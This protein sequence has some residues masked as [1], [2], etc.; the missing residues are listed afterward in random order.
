MQE[1]LIKISFKFIFRSNPPEVFLAKGVLKIWSK[2]KG[3]YPCRN[4]IS[5]KLLCSFTEIAL[6]RGCSPVNLFHIFITP[7]YKNTS[8]GLPLHIVSLIISGKSYT[9]HSWSNP[10]NFLMPSGN[11]K[12]THTS[13]NLHLKAFWST[14]RQNGLTHFSHW[15]VRD[16]GIVKFC[17]QWGKN[18]ITSF[19]HQ[20]HHLSFK[21][22]VSQKEKFYPQFF[23][24]RVLF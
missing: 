6:R 1:S 2:V 24:K 14:H 19:I 21:I 8:G 12:V 13:A 22:Q 10:I 9:Q 5:I 3:E 11:K 7:T 20:S 18:K 23:K 4:L 17:S 16:F 15:I